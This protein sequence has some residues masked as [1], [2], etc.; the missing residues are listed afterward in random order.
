[1]KSDMALAVVF[2]VGVLYLA[3]HIGLWAQSAVAGS[4][5]L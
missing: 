3:Y 2:V 5:P 4:L 1:M